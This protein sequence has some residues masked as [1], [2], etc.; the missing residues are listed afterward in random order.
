MILADQ[1]ADYT[2]QIT[3]CPPPPRLSDLPTVFESIKRALYKTHNEWKKE[4]K[5]SEARGESHF[6]MDRC[7][8]R[9]KYTYGI[10]GSMYSFST[11]CLLHFVAFFQCSFTVV[12]RGRQRKSGGRQWKSSRAG[13]QNIF[14]IFQPDFNIEIYHPKMQQNILLHS[15]MITPNILV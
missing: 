10:W 1:G 7:I 15:G 6:L 8:S 9:R 2:K 4:R 13:Q 14:F 3:T 11:S 12:Y 5:I